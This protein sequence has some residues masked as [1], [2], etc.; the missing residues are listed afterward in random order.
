[1]TDSQPEPNQQASTEQT[2]PPGMA[3]QLADIF[4]CEGEVACQNIRDRLASD[5]EAA[6]ERIKQQLEVAF[7]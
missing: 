7:G 6:C 2:L 4:N 5:K 3:S 1:M